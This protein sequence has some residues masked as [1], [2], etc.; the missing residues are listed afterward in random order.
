[1]LNY[2]PDGCIIMDLL[3]VSAL[4]ISVLICILF[5]ALCLIVWLILGRMPGTKRDAVI[6]KLYGLAEAV[7][8]GVLD[9]KLEAEELKLI[10]TNVLSVIA[11]LKGVDLETI[12]KEFS[13]HAS[14]EE[15]D[16][17]FLCITD[18]NIIPQFQQ[19]SNDE[20]LIKN[21]VRLSDQKSHIYGIIS[22]PQNARLTLSVRS[23]DQSAPD[24]NYIP[25][26]ENNSDIVRIPFRVMFPSAGWNAGEY[27]VFFTLMDES[28]EIV[29]DHVSVKKV[30]SL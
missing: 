15:N 11:A 20:L 18:E 2:A 16:A 29:F 10:L 4:A 9:G 14:E 21:E 5:M 13:D 24:W 3:T 22:A 1:M 6:T 23:K 19:Y 30:D 25:T 26:E 28:Q 8:Y 17:Y 27:D 12:E 7:R